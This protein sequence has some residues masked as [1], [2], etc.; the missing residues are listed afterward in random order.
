GGEVVRMYHLSGGKLKALT[1]LM[2]RSDVPVLVSARDDGIEVHGTAA[3]QEI[4]QAFLRMI[5]PKEGQPAR[6]ADQPGQ[7][8][9]ERK[10]PKA[11][12]EA[13][14]PGMDLSRAKAAE[15]QAAMRGLHE[16]LRSEAR[17]RESE[18]RTLLRQAES[19][20]GEADRVRKQADEVRARAERSREETE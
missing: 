10:A 4:F 1:E 7:P 5:D 3:Q 20:R 16:K 18:L 8:P 2:V 12:S 17:G 11:R 15:L 14:G 6:P 19:M 9:R 13:R